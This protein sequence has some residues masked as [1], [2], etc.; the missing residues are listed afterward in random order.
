MGM[1]CKYC[2]SEI[3]EDSDF[4]NY[5]KKPVSLNGDMRKRNA[6]ASALIAF[7]ALCVFLIVLISG[8]VF[9][10]REKLPLWKTSGGS[11]QV[12]E[13]WIPEG[14][15]QV[16]SDIAEGEYFVWATSHFCSVQVS[17]DSSGSVASTIASDVC[18]TF[19]F[20]SAKS[21]QYLDVSGGSFVPADIAPVPDV[22]EDG[23]YKPGMYRVGIDIPAGEYKVTA[24]GNLCYIQVTKD[25]SGLISSYVNTEHVESQAYVTVVN[26]Q[27]LSVSDG[28][29]APV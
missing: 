26:G 6:V 7:A 21:G 20:V 2:G 14:M 19:M 13:K 11:G 18:E 25:S 24:N 3:P 29:F 16:G 4:C 5:C 22:Q 9:N 12:E 23:T 10:I 27:Y 8:N 28:I 1:Y 17:S 15:Y